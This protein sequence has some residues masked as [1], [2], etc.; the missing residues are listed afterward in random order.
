MNLVLN[1][2]RI[3]TEALYDNIITKIKIKII[4]YTRALAEAFIDKYNETITEVRRV[5]GIA[6]D[7]GGFYPVETLYGLGLASIIANA[8]KL[9]KPVGP[10]DA[11]TALY[12]A[13]FAIQHVA[14]ADLIMPILRALEPLRDKAPLGY[15]VLLAPA[16]SI[17]NLDSGTVEYIR[18]ELNEIYGDVIKGRA[19]SLVN[20]IIAYAN[21]LGMHLVY[22]Y[23]ELENIIGRVVGLLNELGRFKSSLGVI[24]WAYALAPALRHEYVRELMEKALSIDVV[25][26][27]NNEVLKKLSKLRKKVKELM[28]DEEFM[29][30]IESKSVKANEEV[31]KKEI[32]G[33]TSHLKHTLAIYRLH[34]DELDEAEKLFN[35][36]AEESKEIGP[37]ENYLFGHDWVLRTKVIKG[38][39]IGKELVDSFQQLYEETF[40]EGRFKR[41]APYIN[42]ALHILGEYLVS[43]ALTG[44]DKKI[45][46]LLKKHWWVLNANKEVSVLTRLMLNALLSL[47][48]RKDQLGSELKD[49]LSVSLPALGVALGIVKPEDVGKMCVLI[50]DSIKGVRMV[51][52]DSA[53]KWL[54][55]KLVDYFRELLIER[56][57][58]LKGFGVDTDK[59]LDEFRE[60]AYE[61]DGKSLVQLNAPTNSIAL[62]ALMLY[63]LINGDEKLAKAY[64]LRGAVGVG[65]KLPTRLF[66]EAYREC[67]DLGSE[68]FRRAI[69]R[70]FFLHV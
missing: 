44:D 56:S 40:N 3:L 35:K 12:I 26:K 29:S 46:E 27:A 31:V 20:A 70:L 24:A 62:L 60:L 43:L 57:S 37:Y 13:S 67:C 51:C 49:K 41:T 52:G 17:E 33:A 14:S 16:S 21:L 9:S 55:E 63:A 1:N 2:T 22:F 64:A 10:S 59:L 25:D 5:L 45:N 38:S 7:R 65:E 61:L 69:A 34:N 66:L 32:L 54:R 28:R 36:A 15:L 11:G 18:D 19:W 8:A 50:N 58:L 47:K 48:D 23:G 68:E 53:I 39:L 42:A 4:T 6:R 30:Y